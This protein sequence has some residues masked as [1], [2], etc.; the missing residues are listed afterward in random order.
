MGKL[1]YR[2]RPA[3]VPTL[4]TLLLLPSFIAL[5]FWQLRRADEKRALQ[6]EYDLRSNGAPVT[7]GPRLE[8]REDLRFYRVV[9]TGYYEADHQIL[10]DNRVQNGQVGYYVITPLRVVGGDVRLLVNRG[11]VP[12]GFDRAHLPEVAPP[13]GVQ[14]VTGVATVPAERR[15]QLG[16]PPPIGRRWPTVWEYMDMARYAHAAPFPIQPVVV[17][18]DPASAAGGYEREWA[19]LD[20]GIAMHKGYAF[21]WFSFAVVLLTIYLFVNLKKTEPNR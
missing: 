6:A 19:R 12:I 13:S 20:A 16:T 17:L 3:L 18:L 10:L 8:D 14:R 2:F 21:Q 5:G 15:F 11:W 9:A 1:H 4:V 7:I